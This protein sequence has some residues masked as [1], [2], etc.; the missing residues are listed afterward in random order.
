VIRRIHV[1]FTL[2]CTPE[3][4]ETAGRVHGFF[5][6]SCPVY[7]SIHPQINVTTEVTFR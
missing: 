7:R 5:A 2:E 6:Q 3:Q 1:K 4:R